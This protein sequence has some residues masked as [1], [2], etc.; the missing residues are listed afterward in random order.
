MSDLIR[1]PSRSTQSGGNAFE[2][3]A[4]LCVWGTFSLRSKIMQ[5][6][7]A[8]NQARIHDHG[9]V[10]NQV[11]ICQVSGTRHLHL[12]RFAAIDDSHYYMIRLHAYQGHVNV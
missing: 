6:P 2:G 10:I 9:A 4:S 3:V 5:R 7:I 12:I 11:Y 1:V 8:Q